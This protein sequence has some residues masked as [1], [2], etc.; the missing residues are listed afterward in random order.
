MAQPDITTHYPTQRSRTLQHK[1]P[2][3]T[4]KTISEISVDARLLHQRLTQAK[5]GDVITWDD[6]GQIIGRSV[7]P[8]EG[9]YSALATA[10]NRVQVDDGYIFDAIAKV[11]L[12]RLSDAEIVNTGQYAID[13]VRRAARKGTRRLL[14][15]KDFD[16]LPND[17]KVKHNAYA[18]LLGA[19][20]QIS[21]SSKVTQLESHVQNARA[22]LPLAKTLEVFKA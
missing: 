20:A 14:S 11:G 4:K 2:S 10:R 12:K 16:A 9:G 3:M 19:V 1:E 5:V 18:S 13:R 15:V 21:Q 8:G 22:A 17:L 6:L 7:H